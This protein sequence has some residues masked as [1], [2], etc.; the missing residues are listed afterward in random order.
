MICIPVSHFSQ[1]P[2]CSAPTR[3]F[4]NTAAGFQLFLQVLP[5]QPVFKSLLVLSS[6]WLMLWSAFAAHPNEASISNEPHSILRTMGDIG[7]LYVLYISFYSTFHHQ[8]RNK[9]GFFFFFLMLRNL[10]FHKVLV[11]SVSFIKCAV[12]FIFLMHKPQKVYFLLK[13]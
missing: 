2:P 1:L 6:L 7:E 8:S 3:H 11:P 12:N 9:L 10:E 4:H 5:S 13:V